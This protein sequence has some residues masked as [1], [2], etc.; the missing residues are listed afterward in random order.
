MVVE[1]LSDRRLDDRE[2]GRD[3]EVA[4][5]EKRRVADVQDF[6]DDVMTCCATRLRLFDDLDDGG[7]SRFEFLLRAKNGPSLGKP[8]RYFQP[9]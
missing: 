6:M 1:T 3:V 9:T 8:D 7:A 2:M 4:R 5:L